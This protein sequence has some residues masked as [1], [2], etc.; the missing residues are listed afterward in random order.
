WVTKDRYEIRAD[1]RRFENW[2][3]NYA[4][5][6]GLGVAIDYALAW[7]LEDIWTRISSLA[8]SLRTRLSHIPRVQ[9]HDLGVQ[10]CGIVTF[11]IAGWD[12]REIRRKLAEQKINVHASMADSTRLDMDGRGLAGLVRA[13][14]HY[15]NSAE[16]I[17][18]FCDFVT[19]LI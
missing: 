15:Y 10:K 18:R 3:T 12:P 16:E 14:V 4:G 11:A 2:E 6:P 8:S 19:R 7:G 1:A 5:K 17:E 13:S 9:V